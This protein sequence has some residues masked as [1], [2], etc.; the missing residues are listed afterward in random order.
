[1]GGAIDSDVNPCD[2]SDVL[3]ELNAVFN[4]PIPPDTGSRRATTVSGKIKNIAGNYRVLIQAYKT[5]GVADINGWAAYL[6]RLGTGPSG[7]QK[8]YRIAQVRHKALAQGVATLTVIHEFGGYVDTPDGVQFIDSPSPLTTIEEKAAAKHSVSRGGHRAHVSR[9]HNRF[10]P[11]KGG[12]AMGAIDS[13]VPCDGSDV[14]AELNAVFND[15][16][17][18][19]YKYAQSHNTFG[20]IKNVAGNYRVLIQAYRTAGIADINGWAAYLRRLGT[21]PSGPQ[22]IYRI[23][24]VRHKAL[25]QGIATLTVIHEFGGYV[26]TPDG[27]QLI[28]SPSP[29]ATIDEKAAVQFNHSLPRSG[30]RAV[31]PSLGLRVRHNGFTT[32]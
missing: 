27:L 6:K 24:Q 32:L 7:P 11:F 15:P 25:S 23:A 31:E 14:L 19:K 2:G 12:K 16:N 28:D 1:M 13:D 22:K 5:A 3:A 29:L 9:L 10:K 26:D 18:S 17:S 20:K 4:D 30:D 8:I 21:G